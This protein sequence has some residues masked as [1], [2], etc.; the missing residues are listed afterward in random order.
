MFVGGR[1]KPGK[2]G[3]SIT[4]N[5]TPVLV[6]AEVLPK[7]IGRCR[8]VGVPD[9]KGS[10]MQAAMRASVEVSS[11]VRSDAFNA[12]STAVQGYT[13]E[14]T[15]VAF[16][17]VPAHIHLP[18]VSR[19]QSQAKRWL[20]GTLQGAVEAEH[21]QDYLHEFEFRFNRRHARSPAC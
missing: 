13:R 18:A 3:R 1:H 17:R 6:I 2:P 5:K 12:L 9:T 14:R 11:V 19:V 20:L 15:N 16:S 7:G 10:C 21:L 8:F 4:V